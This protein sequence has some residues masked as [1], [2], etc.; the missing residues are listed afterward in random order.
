MGQPTKVVG[1]KLCQSVEDRIRSFD[2]IAGDL[3][4]NKRIYRVSENFIVGAE[5][6]PVVESPYFLV[7]PK[8]HYTSFRQLPLDFDGELTEL[9]AYLLG[10]SHCPTVIMFEHGQAK[11]GN[12]VKSIYHAH[13]HVIVTVLLAMKVIAALVSSLEHHRLKFVHFHQGDNKSGYIARLQA[14][15]ADAPE[16]LYFQVNDDCFYIVDDGTAELPSQYFRVLLSE[17]AFPGVP[18]R[19]WKDGKK[20]DME[21]F[22]QRLLKYLPQP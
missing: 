19:N 11:E 10:I 13:Y 5:K 21:V 1:C 8:Q 12:K 2:E 15:L 6:H 17:I 14:Y 9:V 22:S 18:F 3:P 16:Y 20:E 7:Y 4:D